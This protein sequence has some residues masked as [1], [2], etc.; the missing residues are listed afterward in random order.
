[1][2]NLY[3]TF[4]ILLMDP[5]FLQISATCCGMLR[6][7]SNKY[8]LT[9]LCT[10]SEQVAL[11]QLGWFVTA[12]GMVLKF[13]SCIAVCV[14]S[15]FKTYSPERILLCISWVLCNLHATDDS[16]EDFCTKKV[17]EC[18]WKVWADSF[19]QMSVCMD[20]SK[21]FLCGY[22]YVELEVCRN[23]SEVRME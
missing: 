19:A 8:S 20:K 5:Y 7:P 23:I 9:L 15:D 1:M 2:L 21:T 17:L 22:D 4:D 11:T 18:T 16:T 14:I 10:F 13:D 6:M 3:I 12:M